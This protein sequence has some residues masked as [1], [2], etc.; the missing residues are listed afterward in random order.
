MNCEYKLIVGEGFIQ[1]EGV[2][3]PLSIKSEPKVVM[4]Y[5]EYRGY[6]GEVEVGTLVTGVKP[7][8]LFVTQ[9]WA[10]TVKAFSAEQRLRD[11]P[12][13]ARVVPVYLAMIN[14]HRVMGAGDGT[15][16]IATAKLNGD[17]VDAFIVGEL[18]PNVR[19]IPVSR[20][21]RDNS[22]YFENCLQS[23]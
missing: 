10:T 14:G 23:R 7:G 19:L 5:A 9:E 21:I 4:P 18:P 8:D 1:R 22:D 3:H 20:Y 6:K 13:K 16:R 11:D 12:E 2:L 17:R 15:H